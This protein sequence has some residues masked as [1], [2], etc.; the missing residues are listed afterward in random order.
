MV[1]SFAARLAKRSGLATG[2]CEVTETFGTDERTL[3][4][5]SSPGSVRVQLRPNRPT[6]MFLPRSPDGRPDGRG[7]AGTG[8]VALIGWFC[9]AQNVL[10]S[11]VDGNVKTC[12][13][14]EPQPNR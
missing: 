10:R 2:T 4:K 14:S 1:F 3:V 5:R 12:V 6:W 8:A 11:V 7:S 9:D 13:G